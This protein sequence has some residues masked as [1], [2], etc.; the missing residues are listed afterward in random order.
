MNKK[1]LIIMLSIII[2]MIVIYI[3]IFSNITKN[4]ELIDSNENN[5]ERYVPNWQEVER[6]LEDISVKVLENT[7]RRDSLEILITDNNEYKYGVTHT[8]RIQKKVDGNW[9]ELELLNTDSFLYSSANKFYENNQLRMKLDCKKYYG[10]L[11]NGTYRI[12]KP[13]YS[14]GYFLEQLYSN[15]FEI[16]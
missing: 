6:N 15:E 12:V 1:I 9:K 4:K 13:V 7:I 10:M 3:L 8:F 5:I 11:E 2:I 14:V 16:K